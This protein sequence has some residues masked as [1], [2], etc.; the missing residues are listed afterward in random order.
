MVRVALVLHEH[1]ADERRMWA[2]GEVIRRVALEKKVPVTFSMSGMTIDA[3]ARCCPDVSAGVRWDFANVL[4]GWDVYRPELAISTYH[5][6][7][8]VLPSLELPYWGAFLEGFVA[9]QVRWSK[10]AAE[11]CL[12]RTPRG[13][14][15][16]ELM[17]APVAANVLERSGLHYGF[18]AAEFMGDRRWD[19]G[20]VYQLG[21]L[22]MLPRVNDLHPGDA[23]WVQALDLKNA[24]KGYAR[25]H[26]LDQVLIGSDLGVFTG[27]YAYEGRGGLSL[28]EGIA[29]LC[30]LADAL[31]QD[32]EMTWMN[33]AGLV[34]QY[35]Y[36]RD[37]YS[38][39]LGIADPHHHVATWMNS[40]GNLRTVHGPNMEERTAFVR[41]HTS[42]L[43]QAE[44]NWLQEQKERWFPS[45][46]MER[47][48]HW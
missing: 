29:R 35:S 36:P 11:G 7:P 23:H 39:Y 5:N 18:L 41:W 14:F 45:A 19:K 38:A 47:L 20:Q 31:Y 32:G 4:T 37:L 46:G 40:E 48:M 13:F 33:T 6:T 34:D 9:E 3:L 28:S 27:L 30:C 16:P 21:G 22:K 24:I 25:D 17:F 15:P 8:V 44:G 26:N 12:H 42:Q 43:G 1:Q 10:A 2:V